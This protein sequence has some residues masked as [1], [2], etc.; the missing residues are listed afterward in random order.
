[1]ARSF[2]TAIRLL[3]LS[4][5]LLLG[6]CAGLPPQAPSSAADL[7][8]VLAGAGMLQAQGSGAV[9]D[10]ATLLRV[11]PEMHRFAVNAVEGSFSVDGKTSALFEALNSEQGL[12]IQYDSEAT[13]SAA[14]AFRQRRANCLTFTLLFVALARDAGIPARFN[15]VEIPPVWDLGDDNTLLLYRHINARVDLGDSMYQLVDVSGDDINPHLA[16]QTLITEQEAE[17]QFYN[18]RSAQ[19]RLEHR[20]DESLRYQLFALRLSPQASYLWTNLASLYL[21]QRNPRAAHIAVTRALELD[22]SDA[23]GY[24]TAAQAYEQLGQHDLAAGFHSRARDFLARSPYY[25]YQLA[26]EAMRHDDNR[27][28]YEEIREA[29]RSRVR[30][31]RFYFVL[32]VLLERMGDH[33]HSADSMAVVMELTQ[34]TAQQER[35][36]SKF[37]RLKEQQG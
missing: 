20:L 36:R 35:Y 2:R 28:A 29:V 17:A 18:N 30:D 5:A 26:L 13:L 25:H 15:E 19:L 8:W 3:P 32:A 22:P 10:P 33:Q 6:G 23:L 9:E 27:Q 21:L 31:P 12:H 1:M 37:A 34:D 4:C 14:E 16:Y 24:E 7:S 11:T